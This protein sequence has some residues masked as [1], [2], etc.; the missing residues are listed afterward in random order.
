MGVVTENCGRSVVR[1]KKEWI[2]PRRRY[3]LTVSNAV[4]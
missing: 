1:G 2:I 3:W 4:E